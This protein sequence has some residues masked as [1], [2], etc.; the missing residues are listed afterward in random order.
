MGATIRGE[1]VASSIVCAILND[2]LGSD[3][4]RRNP[5]SRDTVG[6]NTAMTLPRS[7]TSTTWSCAAPVAASR[8][9]AAPLDLHGFVVFAPC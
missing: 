2:R 6:R 1:V 8:A 7:A 3:L 5:W 9:R 4:A